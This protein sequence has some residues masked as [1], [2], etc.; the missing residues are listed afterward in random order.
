LVEDG[1]KLGA[2]GEREGEEATTWGGVRE[3]GSRVRRG[4]GEV[5]KYARVRRMRGRRVNWVS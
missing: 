3:E 1:R 4:D 2:E 5:L